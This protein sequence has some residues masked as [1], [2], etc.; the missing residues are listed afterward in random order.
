MANSNITASSSSSFSFIQPI[1]LDRANYLVW[2]TQV[3]TS[4][5]ANGLEGFINGDKPCPPQFLLELTGESSKS[6]ASM[7]RSIENPEFLAWK[8]IDKMLQ[9]W[10]FSSMVDNVLIMVISCETSQELWNRLVKIFMSQSK[11][12]FT[13]LMI[14]DDAN[15]VHKERISLH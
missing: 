13:P 9:S 5:I 14:S 3:L 11:A 10:M 1:K 4:I 15:T 12:R 8:K 7:A 6:K 2:K